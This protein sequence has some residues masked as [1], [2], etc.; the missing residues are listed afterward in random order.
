MPAWSQP[1]GGPLGIRQPLGVIR[2]MLEQYHALDLATGAPIP[3]SYR[4]SG[5]AAAS[6]DDRTTPT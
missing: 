3:Q 2:S 1:R 6:L 5:L 4:A